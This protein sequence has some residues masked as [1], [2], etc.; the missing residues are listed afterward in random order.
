MYVARPLEGGLDQN[1][2]A[3]DLFWGDEDQAVL[4]PAECKDLSECAIVSSNIYIAYIM[5]EAR[6]GY[7]EAYR[8]VLLGIQDVAMEKFSLKKHI[9]T[10]DNNIPAP[11]Y[12]QENPFIDVTALFDNMGTEKLETL[13]N[14]NILED[15]LLRMPSSTMD[16]SQLS[17]CERI[18][19]KS[20]AIVQ[21]PPGES[22]SPI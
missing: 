10:L 8:H 19:S 21:G 7:F 20:L 14:F 12:L 3:V 13:Q 16:N 2:P 5:V 11:A 4:D 15:S 6:S 17:A 22:S 9:V 1:P 18:L